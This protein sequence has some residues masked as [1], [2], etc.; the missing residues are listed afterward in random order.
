MYALSVHLGKG[1][2]NALAD[3][4]ITGAWI[5]SPIKNHKIFRGGHPFRMYL[6]FRCSSG[7][8]ES[9]DSRL[10]TEP[11]VRVRTRLLM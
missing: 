10:P 6:S 8:R 9:I 11:C 3:L 1:F 4:D 2:W 7:Q 5:I